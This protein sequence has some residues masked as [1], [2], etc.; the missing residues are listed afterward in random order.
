[1]KYELSAEEFEHIEKYRDLLPE[2]RKA[3]DE[4]IKTLFSVT[5]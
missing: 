1:M 3:A 5:F 4:N 2:Y